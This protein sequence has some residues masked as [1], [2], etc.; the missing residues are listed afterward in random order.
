MAGRVLLVEDD[1][2]IGEAL[3]SSLRSHA[4]DVAWERTGAGGLA[5][6]AAAVAR[7]R[8]LRRDARRLMAM[9]DCMLRDVGLGRGEI[10]RAGRGGRA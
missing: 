10:E 7:W 8:R 4:Y 5:H 9:D 1:T 6:A 3:V 2:S